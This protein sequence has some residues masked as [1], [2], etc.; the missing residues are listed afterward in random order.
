MVKHMGR[1][2]RRVSVRFKRYMDKVRHKLQVNER[3]TYEDV[4]RGFALSSDSQIQLQ[5]EDEDQQFR[6]GCR[7]NSCWIQ[8]R[9]PPSLQLFDELEVGAAYFKSFSPP[10][11]TR[12]DIAAKG[13]TK[14]GRWSRGPTV[15]KF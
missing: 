9:R 4:P 12:V 14:S 7:R 13:R 2:R 5:L 6:A 8:V 11:E 1:R 10:G 3:E 15:A